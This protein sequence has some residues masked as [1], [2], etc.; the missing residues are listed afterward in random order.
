MTP[1]GIFL[2]GREIE[3]Q[4]GGQNVEVEVVTRKIPFSKLSQV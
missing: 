1:K 2:L 4:K 3:K